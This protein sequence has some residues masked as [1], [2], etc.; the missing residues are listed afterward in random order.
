MSDRVVLITGFSSAIGQETARLLARQGYVIAATGRQSANHPDVRKILA[1]LP[2][3]TLYIPADITQEGEVKDL[4]STVAG[5]FGRFDAAF[6]NVGGT[7]DVHGPILQLATQDWHRVIDLN[8]TSAML[9]LKHQM[10]RMSETGGG[11]VVCTSGA[12][13]HSGTA[14]MSAYVT[15]KHAVIGLVK[16]AALEGAQLGIRV[17]A[18]SPGMS[19]RNEPDTVRENRER[20]AAQKVPLGRL[21]SAAEI[22]QAAAWLL[23]D[24]ASFVTGQSLVADGGWLAQI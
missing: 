15:A 23:S 10:Q 21:G 1:E 24:Q 2:A 18:L 5:H 16:S 12:L 19:V 11:S 22:A 3:T 4:V 7:L 6:N 14:G 20:A 9:C 13:G 17:N 8:L